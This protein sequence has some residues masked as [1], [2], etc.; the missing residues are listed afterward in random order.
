MEYTNENN[1]K[2]YAFYPPL[3]KHNN[4]IVSDRQTMFLNK[5]VLHDKSQEKIT[6]L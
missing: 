3:I 1:K 2:S 6:L 5:E 4:N